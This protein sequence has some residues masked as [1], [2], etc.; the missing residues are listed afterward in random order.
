LIYIHLK[1]CSGEYPKYPNLK[2][3]EHFSP[4]SSQ[5]HQ[6]ETFFPKIWPKTLQLKPIRRHLQTYTPWCKIPVCYLYTILIP[7]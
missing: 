3:F 1:T 7:M 6:L 2:N 4:N 5:V